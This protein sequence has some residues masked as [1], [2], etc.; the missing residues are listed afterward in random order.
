MSMA[1]LRDLIA[2]WRSRTDGGAAVE[3]ALITPL[4]AATVLNITDVSMYAYDFMQLQNAGQ[5][6]A[7]A[8]WATCNANT[9]GELPATNTTNCPNLQAAV[10][11][12]I[13]KTILGTNVTLSAGSPSEGYY[14]TTTSGSLQLVGTAGTVGSPPSKPN[15]NTCAAVAGASDP[16]AAPGDYIR[17]RVTYTYTPMFSAA[18]VVGVLG[19]TMTQSTMMRLG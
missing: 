4:L 13:K 7:E 11:S 2:A 19:A 15:P 12:A 9:P 5:M 18:S 6:G 14:C 16:T 3:L 8:A 10:S 1:S 17:V